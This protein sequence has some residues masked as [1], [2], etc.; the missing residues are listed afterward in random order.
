MSKERLIDAR[1]SLQSKTLRKMKN[2]LSKLIVHFLKSSDPKDEV[3]DMFDF[4]FEIVER[5]DEIMLAAIELAYN[6]KNLEICKN[7]CNEMR[8]KFPSNEMV[9]VVCGRLLVNSHKLDDASKLYKDFLSLHPC[10]YI[11]IL[12]FLHLMNRMGNYVENKINWFQPRD[13]CS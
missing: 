9:L 2:I 8:Q 6:E 13:F 12:D 11:D 3:A 1:A 7:L 4:I 5:D 10:S